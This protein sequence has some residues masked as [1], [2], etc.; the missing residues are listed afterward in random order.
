MYRFSYTP[1]Q[2]SKI[3][4][5]RW[6]IK[7]WQSTLYLTITLAHLN[8]FLAGLN[9]SETKRDSRMLL[10]NSNRNTDFLIQNLPSDS[11]SEVRFFNLG[12]F[13]N[14]DRHGELYLVIVAGLCVIWLKFCMITHRKIFVGRHVSKLEPE[15]EFCRRIRFLGHLRHR[16]RYL[17][18]VWCGVQVDNGVP[19]RVGCF[20][21]TS[22]WAV[23]IFN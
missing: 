15:L 8:R 9:I 7:T 10:G 2:P 1:L 22:K 21:K 17:H 20:L 4:P 13:A 3:Y 12:C 14:C 19:Q 18:Q 6:F 5:T 16:S 11:R 23:A